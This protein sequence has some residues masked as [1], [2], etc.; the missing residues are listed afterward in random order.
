MSKGILSWFACYKNIVFWEKLKQADKPELCTN[1]ANNKSIICFC[2]TKDGCLYI[3]TWSDVILCR[4]DNILYRC[5]FAKAN[6]GM[7]MMVTQA[8]GFLKAPN[9][10]Q[11]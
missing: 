1:R 7:S 3:T 10:L 9:W 11:I 8:G 2:T 4:V 5:Q 6:F